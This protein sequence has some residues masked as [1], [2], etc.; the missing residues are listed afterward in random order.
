M[1]SKAT[2]S[3]E[4][5]SLI[6]AGV[7][8]RLINETADVS[9]VE[10]AI[11][12]RCVSQ[13]V[14]LVDNNPKTR[15]S[16]KGI[17]AIFSGLAKLPYTPIAL[18]LP[19]GYIY[20]VG[21][22]VSIFALEYW[23]ISDSINETLGPKTRG[24][25]VVLQRS[26]RGRCYHATLLTASTVLAVLSQI[27]GALPSFDYLPNDLKI[28]GFVVILVAG[29]LLPI[30]SLHLTMDKIIQMSRKS[31]LEDTGQKLEKIREEMHAL[32]T[33]NQAIFKEMDIGDKV[34]FLTELNAAKI[35]T[36]EV[37]RLDST[38]ADHKERVP[39]AYLLKMINTPPQAVEGGW[40]ET[41]KKKGGAA[42]GF[43]LNIIFQVA[44]GKYTYDKTHEHLTDSKALAGVLTAGVLGSGLFIYTSAITGG[45][46]AVWN[47]M[48][49]LC[50][51]GES[52]TSISAKLRPA[53]CL[54]MKSLGLIFNVTALGPTWKVWGDF[55]ESDGRETQQFF[56][57]TTAGATFLLLSVA[58][59]ALVDRIIASWIK[60]HGD[61]TEKNILQLYN[62]YTALQT[63]LSETTHLDFIF[64]IHKMPMQVKETLLKKM[65]ITVTDFDEYRIS[66]STNT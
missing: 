60:H 38:E 11:F 5:T 54:A 12:Q 47:K 1:S 62:D 33:K 22:A 31:R 7:Y 53:T 44:I 24:E 51:I 52:D 45:A 57:V 46:Q 61:P 8:E 3:M 9:Y 13:S 55:F 2:L 48:L 50:S 63:I 21:N 65:S 34:A 20:A 19:H 15:K 36:P 4:S 18:Q 10:S 26:G 49:N 64:F 56:Q 40:R 14:Q 6:Q 29:S 37:R 39:A 66:Y 35:A 28:P 23:A 16:M 59:M 41:I 30:R 27:S 17:S 43:A 25:L 42:L 58:T 32:I